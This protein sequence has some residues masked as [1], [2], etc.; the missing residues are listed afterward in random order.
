MNSTVPPTLSIF[1]QIGRPSGQPQVH[2]LS[3]TE[4]K[5]AHVHVLINCNEVKRYLNAFLQYN[6]INDEEASTRIH[7][8]F[9]EWFR[10][11]VSN[12]ANGVTDTNLKSLAL[13]P[14]SKATTW[15]EYFI[16]G[17][18]FHTQAWSEGKPTMNSGVYVKGLQKEKMI[19]TE[20]SKISSNWSIM[21]CL[22]K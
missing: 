14:N 22:T 15:H 10:E 21:D 13:G 12:Q 19:F 17:Y 4:W 11:Y 2:W 16:N 9:S 20:S 8:E 5:S 6:S 7:G 18:E 3:D 1:N